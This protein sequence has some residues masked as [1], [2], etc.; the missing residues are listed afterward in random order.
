MK[1]FWAALLQL[2]LI[3]LNAIFASAEIAVISMNEAKLASLKEKGGKDAKKAKALA[4]LTKDPAKFLS[5]IQVAITLAGFLG[6]AFAAD[7]FAEPLAKVINEAWGWNFDVIN[8]VCVILITIILAFFNIVFGELVPKRIAMNRAEKVATGL[9]G[10]LRAV[11]IVFKPIVWLLSASTNLVLKIFGI[12]PEDKG[13]EITEDDIIMMAEVGAESGNIESEENEMIKNIFELGDTTIGEICTH[14]KDADI[15]YADETDREWKKKIAS[16]FH[17]YYPILD[18]DEVKGIL[19]TKNYF[20]LSDLSREN[21]M[22]K[23][24]NAP[25]YLYENS[26]ASAVFEQMKKTHEYFAIVIDEYGAMIG[27]ITIHDLLE[28]IVGDM[29]EKGDE[30]EYAIENKGENVWEITGVVPLGEFE[31]AVG[32]IVREEEN[33]QAEYD[34]FNGYVCSLMVSVPKDGE[35]IDLSTDQM[36]IHILEVEKQRINKMLVE[37]KEQK[38]EE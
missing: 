37:I 14:R 5:T 18:Q 4:K 2:V 6:S 23:A 25:V 3:I 16:T 17:T 33:E 35:K 32:F 20:R 26:S 31:E 10:I 19:F 27:I 9:T 38:E 29:D 15:L 21:V 36:D 24:V 7:M 11:S 28:A 30:I 34:T 1:Y 22:K 13:E 8:T 12:N